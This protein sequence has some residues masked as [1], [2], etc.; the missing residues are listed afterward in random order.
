MCSL[1]TTYM[2]VFVHDTALAWL[3]SVCSSDD[4][5][6]LATISLAAAAVPQPTDGIIAP[7]SIHRTNAC[8]SEKE[9]TS[10]RVCTYAYAQRGGARIRFGGGF[11]QS[12]S[13]ARTIISNSSFVSVWPCPIRCIRQT[14]RSKETRLVPVFTIWYIIDDER[15][16]ASDDAAASGKAF[17]PL[18]SDT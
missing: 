6:S 2:R 11:F 10:S 1:H 3:S 9:L 15:A 18:P 7:G 4:M 13:C 8:S 14:K 16:F 12:V 17:V 5:S